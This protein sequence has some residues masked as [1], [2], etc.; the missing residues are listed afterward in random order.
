R[1]WVANVFFRESLGAAYGAFIPPNRIMLSSQRLARANVNAIR[2]VL[3]AE[4]V[5]AAQ[6]QRHPGMWFATKAAFNAALEAEDRSGP[7]RRACW[8]ARHTDQAR[9][10]GAGGQETFLAEWWVV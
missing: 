7:S 6:F 1:E 2:G 5:H 3:F 4:L 8:D 10:G 9:L